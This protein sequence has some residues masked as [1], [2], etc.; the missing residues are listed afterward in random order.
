M[1]TNKNIKRIL[2]MILS[3]ALILALVPA[4]FADN[5]GSVDDIMNMFDNGVQRPR[6]SSVLSTPKQMYVMSKYG[7]CIYAQK[8]PSE[9]A[10]TLYTIDEGRTVTVYAIQ[11]GYALAIVKGAAYGGW[12]KLSL[13]DEDYYSGPNPSDTKN[14][15]KNV[16]RPI[17]GDYIDD[18]ETMYVRSKY[19][20]RIY[21]NNKP[22][23]DKENPAEVIG[24]IYEGEEVT[25]LARRS[26]YSFVECSA[27][28][29]WCKTSLLVY[30][31]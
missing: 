23:I 18:Y 29:G 11:S 14:L 31:Y 30:E 26:G 19:G 17:K 22:D 24:Y 1:K 9:S 3:L 21:L 4:V 8:A 20:V 16:Q 25:V 2:S 10:K 13:L 28:L 5:S 15:P 27:G 6:S 12:M 7:N